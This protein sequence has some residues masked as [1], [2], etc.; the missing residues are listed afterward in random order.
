MLA[1]CRDAIVLIDSIAKTT[2]VL[3]YL[4]DTVGAS[5]QA[6]MDAAELVLWTSRRLGEVLLAAPKHP[7]GWPC[8]KPVILDDRF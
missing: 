5:E 2:A 6:V 8:E 1:Q 3:R 7:G 4:R